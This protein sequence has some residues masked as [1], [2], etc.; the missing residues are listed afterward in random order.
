MNVCV[1]KPVAIATAHTPAPSSG[2]GIFRA[3][4]LHH[5]ANKS[6]QLQQLAI[7]RIIHQK[8]ERS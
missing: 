1:Q 3:R 7:E 5:A 2:E 8:L 4:R 6:H